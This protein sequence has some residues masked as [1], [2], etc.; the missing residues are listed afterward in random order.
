LIEFSEGGSW[1]VKT[2]NVNKL[3]KELA[4]WIF[5]PAWGEGEAGFAWLMTLVLGA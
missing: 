2:L 5:G 1:I 4:N 3:S